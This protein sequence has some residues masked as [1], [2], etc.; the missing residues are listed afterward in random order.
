MTQKKSIADYTEAEFLDFLRLID[1]KNESAEEEELDA[2][3]D[4]FEALTEHPSGTDLLYWPETEAQGE[5]EQVL[6][7][8]K[9]WRAANGKPGFKPE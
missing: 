4:Q 2:L 7:I 5:I 9:E 8:I 3:L 6:I 1:E